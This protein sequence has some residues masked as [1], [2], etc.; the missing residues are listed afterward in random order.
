[1]SKFFLDTEF[2][3]DGKTIDLLTIAI[4]KETGEEFYMANTQCDLNKANPW[5]LENVFGQIGVVKWQLRE[6]IRDAVLKFVG[7][8]KPEIWSYYADYDWVAVCQLFGR[9]ID[10]PK[11]WP[12][13][14]RDL[15]Q[16]LDERNLR[17]PFEPVIAHNA[18]SDARWLRDA[19]NWLESK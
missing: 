4:V 16:T 18:L 10:L 13:Y 14:C 19:Y 3:E 6:H 15:K 7:Q 17:V 1:M 12:M 2:I 11:G 9:M 8:D 5:V